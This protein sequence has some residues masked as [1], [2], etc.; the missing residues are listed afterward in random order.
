MITT[1]MTTR[2]MAKMKNVK[3]HKVL[4]KKKTRK[5][6]NKIMLMK[7]YLLMKRLKPLKKSKLKILDPHPKNQSA[8]KRMKS[9]LN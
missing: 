9:I 2:L 3:T 7:T 4:K 5:A 8:S 6:I 1:R